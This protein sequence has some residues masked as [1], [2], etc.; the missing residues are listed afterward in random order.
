ME[1]KLNNFINQQSLLKLHILKNH[2]DKIKLL[3]KDK[4]RWFFSMKVIN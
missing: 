2:R 4:I 1:N 3:K